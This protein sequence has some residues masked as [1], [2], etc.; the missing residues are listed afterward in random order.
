MSLLALG[1]SPALAYLQATATPT[2]IPL[3]PT[4]TQVSSFNLNCPTALPVGWGT[5]TPGLLWNSSCGNC[6]VTLLAPTGTPMVSVTP[7]GPTLTPTV[8]ATPFPTPSGGNAL[9]VEPQTG[10]SASNTHLPYPAASWNPLSYT[11]DTN[12][13]GFVIGEVFTVT[14]NST[15]LVKRM[16]G[17]GSELWGNSSDNLQS[18]TYL[19]MPNFVSAAWTNAGIVVTDLWDDQ[20]DQSQWIIENLGFPVHLI[21]ANEIAAEDDPQI[22][23]YF[24][25]GYNWCSGTVDVES[26]ALI[27][28]GLDGVAEPTATPVVAD[29]CGTVNGSVG[30]QWELGIELPEFGIGNSTC[31]GISEIVLPT[32]IINFFPGIDIDDVTVP[33]IELCFVE[34]TFG[35]LDLFGVSVNLDSIANLLAAA[36]IIRWLLRS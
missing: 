29:Y 18:A 16:E 23:S 13:D 17:S 12:I 27:G 30:E 11:L 35:S 4:S 21:V 1:T 32:S 15:C 7:G 36:L 2:F 14:K 33:G 22:Y 5:V 10:G 31:Y 9:F 26:V 19:S 3:F 20:A 6:Q 28:W 24:E 34:I 25:H 8:T